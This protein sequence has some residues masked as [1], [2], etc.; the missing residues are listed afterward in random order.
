MPAKFKRSFVCV[1]PNH[2]VMTFDEW[3]PEFSISFE[4]ELKDTTD[5]DEWY[6]L[7]QL[8]ANDNFCCS[9]GDRVPGIWLIKETDTTWLFTVDAGKILFLILVWFS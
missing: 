1:G 4:L 5:N 6:D 7:L 9:P 8:T 2:T 3:G